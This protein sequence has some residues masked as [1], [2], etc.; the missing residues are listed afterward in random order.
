MHVLGINRQINKDAVIDRCMAR[1]SGSETIISSAKPESRS[2][3][4]TIPVFVV[5]QVGFK[6][7]DRLI[8]RVDKDGKEWMAII[9]K[10][11]DG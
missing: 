1:L 9:R 8:W 4:T 5:E 6:D 3:R 10:K 2:L 7:G 11:H